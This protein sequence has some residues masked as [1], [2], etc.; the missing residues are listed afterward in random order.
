[1]PSRRAAPPRQLTCSAQNVGKAGRTC[2]ATTA[3]G[4]VVWSCARCVMTWRRPS[5]DSRGDRSPAARPPSIRWRGTC[6]PVRVPIAGLAIFHTLPPEQPSNRSRPP[7]SAARPP[8]QELRALRDVRRVPCFPPASGT[9]IGTARNRPVSIACYQRPCLEYKTK[10]VTTP[11]THWQ[12]GTSL[13]TK[14]GN[15]GVDEMFRDAVGG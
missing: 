6:D 5:R 15:R 7:R 8:A 10:F 2:Q 1:M 13:R 11:Y 3:K 9:F 4:G 12:K 14:G